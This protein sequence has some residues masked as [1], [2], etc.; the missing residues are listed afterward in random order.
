MCGEAEAMVGE[1]ETPGGA[2][3]GAAERDGL[4]AELVGR[5]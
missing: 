1:S 4:G 2:T 5:R 3:A